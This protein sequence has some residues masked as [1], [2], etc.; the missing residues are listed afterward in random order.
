MSFVS[1]LIT[2][3]T[4]LRICSLSLSVVT[5]QILKHNTDAL[6]NFRGFL[7][8]NPYVDPFSN[9]MS[10]FATFYAHG[11]L[12]KPLYDEF[13]EKCST[14]KDLSTSACYDLQSQMRQ[15]FG[16]GINPYALDY[17]VCTE[18]KGTKTKQMTT[19]S[20]VKTFLK[21][22]T[23]SIKD[24][25]PFLPQEDEYYPC[26]EEHL[27]K[28]MNRWGVQT[29]LHAHVGSKWKDCSDVLHYAWQDVN[30]PQIHLFRDLVHMA[31]NGTHDLNILVFSGDDDSVCSTAGTQ[32]WI[33]NIGVDPIHGHFWEPWQVEEQ[34][35]GF[36]TKFDMGSDCKA[37]F[38]FVTIHGAGHEVPAYRPME[39]LEMFKRYLQGDW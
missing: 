13:L 16:E 25:P 10:Q 14:P 20:Q 31:K 38:T 12:T 9:T 28:Y 15:E 27:H 4:N 3:L 30:T 34:T 35:A 6:I 32:E 22:T 8:G 7:V 36:V 24:G 37:S 29:A 1:G 39:A 23:S 19:S 18:E 5:M 26:K 11:L 33:Y 2:N 17:P 21:H